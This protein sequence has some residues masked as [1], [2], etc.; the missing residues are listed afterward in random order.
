M[1]NKLLIIISVLNEVNNMLPIIKKIF[2]FLPAKKN[3]FYLLITTQKMA[4][5]KKFI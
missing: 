4:Q 2:K 5:E 1:Q 3:I